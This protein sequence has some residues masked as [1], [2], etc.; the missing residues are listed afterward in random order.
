LG[1]A[2]T[3]TVCPEAQNRASMRST[4]CSKS[5]LESVDAGFEFVDGTGV[6]GSPDMYASICLSF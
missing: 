1:G 6:V 5:V 3:F 4:I 2:F